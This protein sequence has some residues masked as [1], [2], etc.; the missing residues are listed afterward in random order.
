[1]VNPSSAG[2]NKFPDDYSRKKCLPIPYIVSELPKAKRLEK[3]KVLFS[4]TCQE[5]MLIIILA[6]TLL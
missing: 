6:R 3:K 5:R 2:R 1:M 4:R